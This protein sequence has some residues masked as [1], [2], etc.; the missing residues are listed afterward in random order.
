MK[1][2]I[3]TSTHPHSSLPYEQQSRTKNA[4]LVAKFISGVTH[5][6]SEAGNY[7]EYYILVCVGM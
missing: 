7:G 3:H 5:T 1:A 6:R 2:Y 4:H